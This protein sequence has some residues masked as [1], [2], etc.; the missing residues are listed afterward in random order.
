MV[1]D[2]QNDDYTIEID[3]G[4][5]FTDGYVSGRGTVV[6]AKADTTPFDLAA[7][8]LACIERAAEQL[9]MARTELLRSTAAVRLSTTVGTN[10]L[11]NRNGPAVGLILGADTAITHSAL[12]PGLP[13]DR[14]LVATVD[15]SP[16]KDEQIQDAARQ[17]LEHGARVLVIAL[18]GG[19]SLQERE[20]AARD[21][22]AASYPRHY[23]GAVPVLPSHQ[24]TPLADPRL[25]VHAAV[26]S[27]YLHPVMSSFLYRLEDALR[28]DGYKHPML[29]AN[30]DG[31]TS[32]VAKT[33][34]LRTWGSGPAGGVAA[35]A[36]MAEDLGLP[37]VVGYDVG[38]TSTD[39][40]V[41]RHGDWSYEVQPRVEGIEL[42]LPSLALVSAP[43]GGGTIARL[44]AG[45]LRLGPDSAGAQPGPACFGLG[46]DQVT[47]T[48]A[49]ARLGF[50]DPTRFLGGRKLLDL[51]AA[52]RVLDT[53]SSADGREATAV[54]LQIVA[55]AGRMIADAVRAELRDD[56]R[57][58]PFAVF[59]TGG[60]GGMLAPYVHDASGAV[61]TYA[62]SVSP[63]FSAFGLSRLAVRHV[64]EVVADR[65]DL[66]H[67]LARLRERALADMRTEG[68][69]P[70]QVSFAVETEIVASDGSVSVEPGNAASDGRA[71]LVRLVVTS[72][73]REGALPGA[74]TGSPVP[75]SSR[76]TLWPN[77][78]L[79]T[80]VYD[81]LSLPEGTTIEGPAILETNETT[82]V[83]GP[84]HRVA[85]GALG[86]VRMTSR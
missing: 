39:V 20:T 70:D 4:G 24:I 78:E 17:L 51:D 38:G 37:L 15:E 61:A 74:G 57:D 3:T 29:V 26:L 18:S 71:R 49:V 43:I 62:F 45:V 31:G 76:R 69:A 72:R 13:L 85:I 77:G 53:M 36:V 23:L 21:A 47:V 48:D 10:T 81:W 1:S 7:G 64:Y 8:V 60:A 54:A 56:E 27:A 25:R 83:A 9:G 41:V 19:D 68:Y 82:F 63:V 58:A 52:T 34:A 14:T 42:P 84:G 16:H 30:A 5:T 75:V 80:P 32:R 79:D 44:D 6:A 86:E 33:T 46:G 55:D 12:S 67:E 50:F 66:D 28:E 59:A 11:I 40:S 22:I 73:A 35:T 65:P 2:D